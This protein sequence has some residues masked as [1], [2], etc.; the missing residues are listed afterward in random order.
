M[1]FP[2]YLRKSL[3]KFR[4]SSHKLAIETGRHMGILRG[5]RL[6]TYCFNNNVDVVEDEFQ[7]FF[8]CRKFEESR[9][10]YLRHLNPNH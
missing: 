8:E 9:Q 3:A 4:C 5:E 2:F 7:V 6:C 1:D 10:M